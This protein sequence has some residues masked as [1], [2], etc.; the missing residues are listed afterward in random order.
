MEKNKIINE[1]TSLVQYYESLNST[2]RHGLISRLVE[3]G[4]FND[5]LLE[6][7]DSDLVELVFD[8]TTSVEEKELFKQYTDYVYKKTLGAL[9]S[10]VS[11]I[12]SELS[13]IID[14]YGT[15]DE[16]KNEVLKLEENTR[17]LSRSLSNY[18]FIR[19]KIAYS[20][21]MSSFDRYKKK[22]IQFGLKIG[23]K[24]DTLERKKGRGIIGRTLATN[25]IRKLKSEIS[26]L[27]KERKTVTG[28]LYKKY[29]EVAHEY[30][31]VM[32]NVFMEVVK[33]KELKKAIVFTVDYIYDTKYAQVDADGMKHI[34]D[35]ELLK[36]DNTE[37]LKYFTLFI[38]INDVNEFNGE[39][40]EEKFKEFVLYF[41]KKRIEILNFRK[42]S[43][44]SKIK[45]KVKS[46]TSAVENLKKLQ[47]LLL[48]NLD[49]D[50]EFL[51]KYEYRDIFDSVTLELKK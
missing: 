13:E 49:K 1:V 24:A 45:L 42:T 29:S 6:L 32:I 2:S 21:M 7:N 27:K 17:N 4:K 33:N 48:R 26:T 47:G 34:S 11:V 37:L 10:S 36:V 46:Q 50:E 31:K 28:E 22:D 8:L 23:G 15:N 9:L 16:I 25:D 43:N 5:G 39:L 18:P 30:N 3:M 38:N 12:D 44:L 41:Y 19:A 35:E 20:N 51:S 14:I 40:F